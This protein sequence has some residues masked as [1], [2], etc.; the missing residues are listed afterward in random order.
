MQL[1]LVVITAIL[2]CFSNIEC[3]CTSLWYMLVAIVLL[4]SFIPIVDRDLTTHVKYVFLEDQ[5]VNNPRYED[6]QN[7]TPTAA[8]PD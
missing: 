2:L 8:N 5:K 7:A 1:I 3:G 4:L 6:G